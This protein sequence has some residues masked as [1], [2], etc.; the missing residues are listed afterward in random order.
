MKEIIPVHLNQT[1]RDSD[2][3][4]SNMEGD[5]VQ[6]LTCTTTKEFKCETFWS[7]PKGS[8]PGTYNIKAYD[9][10]SSSETKFE[11]IMK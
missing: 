4:I 11:I 3:K 10:I 7:I 2:K 8:I 9:S 6:E 5:S 1:T